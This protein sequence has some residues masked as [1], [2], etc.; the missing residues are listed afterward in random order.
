MNSSKALGHSKMS[1]R[2]LRDAVVAYF[3]HIYRLQIRAGAKAEVEAVKVEEGAAGNPD[4]WTYELRAEFGGKCQ[5]RRMSIA[6]L[7]AESGSKSTCFYVIYDNHLVVK[8]PPMPVTDFEKY[9]ES[10][11]A[12]HRIV[13]RLKP[14]ECIVPSVSAIL[15]RIYTFEDAENLASDQLEQRYFQWLQ[16]NPGI[17]KILQISG[18]FVFF[19]D[20][21]R[22]F[23]LGDVLKR[24]H[25]GKQNRFFDEITGNPGLL[26]DSYG[27]EGRY[28]FERAVIAEHV[29]RVYDE[30]EQT[31]K[32]LLRSHRV[33][34]TGM[35]YKLQRWFLK[36]LA[37]SVVDEGEED[38]SPV[39][40]EKINELLAGQI[41]KNKQKVIPYWETVNWFLFQQNF[42]KNRML[43]SGM[44]NNILELM[45]WLGN[46]GVAMRD[47]KPDNLLVAGDSEKFPHFLS[48]PEAYSLGLIDVETAVVYEAGNDGSISQ[49]ALGG[50]PFY[51]T[52]SQF[53]PNSVLQ[54]LFGDIGQ[55]LCLQDWYAAV[56][57]VFQVIT[58]KRPFELTARLMPKLM[59]EIR[60]AGQSRQK[61]GEVF[62]TVSCR[63]W[64][65]A[66]QEFAEN[67]G[68][69]EQML[70][71]VKM[72]LP[73]AA[74]EMMRGAVLADQRKVSAW[75]QQVV[76]EQS[77]FKS[78]K[79]RRQLLHAPVER[80]EQWIQQWRKN[81]FAQTVDGQR[82]RD[83]GIRMLEDVRKMKQDLDSLEQVHDILQ[84]EHAELTAHE[85]LGIMFAHV[86]RGMRPYGH[87]WRGAE[88][89]FS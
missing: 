63:F 88:S 64:D 69:K 79:N 58:D 24:I 7:G 65:S 74:L 4:R 59:A 38:L 42:S 82:K 52:P 23:I 55:T 86:H 62:V 16:D 5:K 9:R 12:E 28:G 66:C 40:V 73:R 36:H 37:G 50:T 47:F 81:A 53:F 46:K 85:L 2:E 31:V 71:A 26:W 56:A 41:E 49:P 32:E 21:S 29:Q 34:P 14:L 78:D 54:E 72:M 44:I 70:K 76:A 43:M 1:R 27:F 15:K 35:Q 61:L 20:L 25:G 13:D 17:Q 19:M 11:Y 77:V 3:L 39:L 10:I 30:Y 83:D 84:F 33:V 75:L 45:A 80:I 67:C 87:A 8:I 57:M 22:Y 48:T 51:T 68:K 18:T 6:P 60:S 89:D